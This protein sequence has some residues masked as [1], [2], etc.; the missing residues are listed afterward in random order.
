M[1]SSLPAA[2][3]AKDSVKR[4]LRCVT[5]A[6]RHHSAS[7][8]IFATLKFWKAAYAP[9]LMLQTSMCPVTAPRDRNSSVAMASRRD[10][11]LLPFTFTFTLLLLP[12]PAAKSLKVTSAEPLSRMQ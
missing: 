5:P 8:S 7:A 12:F 3:V 10:F 2:V 6:P 11:S 9:M 1:S 4:A